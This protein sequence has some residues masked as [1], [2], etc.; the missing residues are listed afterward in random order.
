MGWMSM[1]FDDRG[2]GSLS[3]TD[4][5]GDYLDNTVSTDIQ[6]MIEDLL[7][8]TTVRCSQ[9]YRNRNIYRCFFADGTWISI[10]MKG[11]RVSGLMPCAYPGMVPNVCCS[12]E[13]EDGI[14]RLFI[15]ADDG[16]VYQQETANSFDEENI[17]AHIRPAFHHSGSPNRLKKYVQAELDAVIGPTFTIT[18]DFRYDDGRE[19]SALA[20]SIDVS[21]AEGGG[22]WDEFEWDD[23]TWDK[24]LARIGAIKI[25]GEGTN[26]ATAFRHASNNEPRHTL[27]GMMLTWLPRRRDRRSVH[28]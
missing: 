13:D 21:V 11:R 27:R 25:E 19:E 24:G 14:E 15:G 12:E 6:P 2:F 22:Y 9:L 4:R 8:E 28:G 20:E 18:A 17:E 26:V 5:Y 23:F 3:S 16:F 7:E 10:G 1:F